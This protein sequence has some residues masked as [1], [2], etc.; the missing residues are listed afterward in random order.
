[1]IEID[2]NIDFMNGENPSEQYIIS[3]LLIGFLI[4]T[5]LVVFC[6]YQI[7]NLQSAALLG[8][9][10]ALNAEF[11]NEANAGIIYALE[12]DKPILIEHKGNFTDAQLDNY[13]DDLNNMDAAYR[14]G[15]LT[16]NGLCLSYSYYIYISSGNTEI[17]NYIASKGTDFYEG[18]ADLDSVVSG[19]KD[20]DCHD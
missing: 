17:S 1:M 2:T 16:E 6:L 5:A 11:F 4:L 13:L 10:V 7:H 9:D 14:D 15:V 18:L 12:L 3:A 8:N 19:S 20:K